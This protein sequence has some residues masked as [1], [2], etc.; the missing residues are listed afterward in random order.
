MMDDNNTDSNEEFTVTHEQLHDIEERVYETIHNIGLDGVFR[1]CDM[2]N[3]DGD[4]CEIHGVEAER[5]EVG[6]S[7]VV[8]DPQTTEE[9]L[10]W[11]LNYL[12]N[13]LSDRALSA[14]ERE[15]MPVVDDA[16]AAFGHLDPIDPILVF[17]GSIDRSLCITMP[18]TIRFDS[19]LEPH[20]ILLVDRN[21]FG[22]RCDF[23]SPAVSH[24][25]DTISAVAE[26]D[27]VITNPDAVWIDLS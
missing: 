8:S 15:E 2:T 20:K 6:F 21:T 22:M 10:H 3:V 7:V 27:Y 11:K 13:V 24:D 4:T 26:I 1:T 25:D 19:T 12:R 14:I 17:P 16:S 23:S 9:R 18:V 5:N